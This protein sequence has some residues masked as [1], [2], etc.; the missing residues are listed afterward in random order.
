MRLAFAE[1]KVTDDNH[2]PRVALIADHPSATV[3]ET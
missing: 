2:V 3:R 1:V